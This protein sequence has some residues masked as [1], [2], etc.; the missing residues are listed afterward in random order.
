VQ[1]PLNVPAAP[2]AVRVTYGWKEKGAPKTHVENVPAE[3]YEALRSRAKES[4]T[5]ISAEVLAILG[6]NVP[7]RA[8]LA[9]RKQ[10]LKRIIRLQSRPPA[11]PG[12]F[13]STEEMQRQDRER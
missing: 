11:S 10:L 12:S 1:S 9:H 3:L 6:Q 5:S 4:R 13:L 7:T 8:E 2:Q